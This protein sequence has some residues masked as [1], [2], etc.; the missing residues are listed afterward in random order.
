MKL[1]MFLKECPNIFV[2]LVVSLILFVLP[3]ETGK[4]INIEFLINYK[5]QSA[6]FIFTVTKALKVVHREKLITS[7]DSSCLF[8]S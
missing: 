1:I 8:L 4:L 3:S 6:I 2:L 5:T 7:L